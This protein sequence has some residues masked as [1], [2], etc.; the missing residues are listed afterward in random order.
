[1]HYYIM[2]NGEGRQYV[3]SMTPPSDDCIVLTKEEYVTALE[4]LYG[5]EE[6]PEAEDTFGTPD[7]GIYE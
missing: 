6:P 7:E 5:G 1:M 2:P 3:A 4:A